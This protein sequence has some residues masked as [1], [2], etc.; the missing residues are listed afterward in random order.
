MAKLE[1]VSLNSS[2]GS[3]ALI[4]EG[5]TLRRRSGSLVLLVSWVVLFGLS[6]LMPPLVG[7]GVLGGSPGAIFFNSNIIDASNDSNESLLTPVSSPGVSDNPVLGAIFNT[8]TN[9]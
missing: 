5:L 2:A 6:S 1:L 3:L 7:P 9:D 8:I 4:E